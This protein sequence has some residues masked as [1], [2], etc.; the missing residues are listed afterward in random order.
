[1]LFSGFLLPIIVLVFS[2]PGVFTELF[3]QTCHVCVFSSGLYL[4]VCSFVLLSQSLRAFCLFSPFSGS[5]S[6]LGCW[7]DH[8]HSHSLQ[9]PS[10]L[11]IQCWSQGIQTYTL[12]PASPLEGDSSSIPFFL[13]ESQSSLCLSCF[14]H[15][16]WLPVR[17]H[18]GKKVLVFW[19]PVC[20]TVAIFLK[21]SPALQQKSL[22]LPVLSWNK[23][24]ADGN[25][26]I[27]MWLLIFSLYC[28]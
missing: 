5:P 20:S 4:P 3:M 1:M 16:V 24:I 2:T 27:G 28:K 8:V 23:L 17:F 26:M 22:V 10:L 15:T 21:F 19:V 18:I 12:W 11:P 14:F 13:T 25:L 9:F 7:A 6:S